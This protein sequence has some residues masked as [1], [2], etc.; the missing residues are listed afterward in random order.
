MKT[1]SKMALLGLVGLL[2]GATPVEA[3]DVYSTTELLLVQGP[4]VERWAVQVSINQQTPAAVRQQTVSALVQMLDTDGDHRLSAVEAKA[5][6]SRFCWRQLSAGRLFASAQPPPKTYDL[7][8]DG[9]FTAAELGAYFG[10]E[11]G[12]GVVVTLATAPST[13]ELNR[14]LLAA[15]KMSEGD[16]IQASRWQ[17]AAGRLMS[18][19]ANGDELVGAGE[20]L[21]GARY[22]GV[23][24][25]SLVAPG[26]LRPDQSLMLLPPGPASKPELQQLNGWAEVLMNR[27]DLDRDGI[28]DR[29]EMIPAGKTSGDIGGKTGNRLDLKELI[30]WRQL[31]AANQVYVKLSDVADDAD[32]ASTDEASADEAGT[33]QKFSVSASP[34]R[35]VRFDNASRSL[36]FYVTSGRDKVWLQ[37]IDELVDQFI[38]LAK[39]S[40]GKIPAGAPHRTELLQFAALMD[41]DG[42]QRV[43]VAEAQRWR[44]WAVA[45]R[46]RQCVI[47]VADLQR[48]L[49]AMLDVSNDGSLSSE[50][51]VD[52]WKIFNSAVLQNGR[53]KLA[54]VPHQWR[55][56]I[57]SSTPTQLL[58]PSR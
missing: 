38:E 30:K 46:V 9:Y 31:P 26:S 3:G 23:Q 14:A 53:I 22:P 43:S 4:N 21:D 47:S 17:A 45:T 57:G 55:V 18:L 39:N 19:D 28:L 15:L 2:L 50:E 32:E 44:Q 1:R 20:L 11:S 40:A 54:A 8:A 36:Q 5:L 35:V 49:F 7:D 34:Q 27:L 24:A 51:L 33:I 41:S 42:N 58:A 37:Q 52:G 16:V 13:A 25:T 6:P 12:G 56:F 48:S 10:S 29:T